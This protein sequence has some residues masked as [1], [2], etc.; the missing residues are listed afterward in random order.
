MAGALGAGSVAQLLRGCSGRRPWLD[1]ARE[2]C[3]AAPEALQRGASNVYFAVTRGALSIPP[4]TDPFQQELVAFLSQFP[5][6]LRP[7]DMSQILRLRF[8]AEDPARVQ[9]CL[10]RLERLQGQVLNLR[11]AEYEVLNAPANLN[12]AAFETSRQSVG[13]HAGDFLD[14]VVAIPRLREVRAITGF[15]RLEAPELD[16]TMEVLDEVPRPI[17]D[18]AP[19]A[20]RAQDW[21]PAIENLGEGIFMRLRADRLGIWEAKP[22]VLGRSGALLDAYSA[23]R[24]SRGLPPL[25]ARPP[26]LILLH[27]LAHLLMRQLA[28]DSGYSSTSIR[29]RIYAGQGMAGILLYTATPDSDGSLGGLVRQAREVSLEGLILSALD[30]A[31]VCSSDPLCREHDALR[32]GRLNGAACHACAMASETSCEFG[33]RLLDRALVVPLPGMEGLSFGTAARV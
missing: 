8:P 13:P 21:L 27:T 25:G 18:P 14:T 28:L 7:E 19:L 24:Q 30:A 17:P 2:S 32:T 9:E 10:E 1:A 22:E 4:W 12:E 15:T 31:S 16:P 26:R 5:G 33:N 29:E 3:Q 23:W 20:A 6:P 11:S